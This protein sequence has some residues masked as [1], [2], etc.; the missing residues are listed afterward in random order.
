MALKKKA[1]LMPLDV[2]STDFM[3]YF[4]GLHHWEPA[5]TT[6]PATL[7]EFADHL[8]NHGVTDF[9][10]VSDFTFVC[11][12]MIAMDE[13][14]DEGPFTIRNIEKCSFEPMPLPPKTALSVANFGSKIPKTKIDWAT[15][16]GSGDKCVVKF[17]LQYSDTA[18]LK[19]IKPDKPALLLTN[20]MNVKKGKVYAIVW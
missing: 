19:G 16:K 4:S 13:D 18:Q 17:H 8:E 9:S 20:P 6:A 5:F 7:A 15:G 2:N 14:D 1:N 12:E 3:A 11:H 10:F